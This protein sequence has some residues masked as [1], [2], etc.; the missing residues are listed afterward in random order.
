VGHPTEVVVFLGADIP[1]E[2]HS[3]MSGLNKMPRKILQ[4]NIPT[5]T[6]ERTSNQ[7]CYPPEKKTPA[8]QLL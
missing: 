2:T 7:D 3:L 8:E 6:H 4:G 5:N 1:A